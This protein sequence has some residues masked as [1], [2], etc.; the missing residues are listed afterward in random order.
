MNQARR[1]IPVDVAALTGSLKAALPLIDNPERR[2]D[3]ERYL[4]STQLLMER[5]VHNLF[6]GIVQQVNEAGGPPLRLDYNAGGLS[7][8]IEPIPETPPEPEPPAQPYNVDVEGDFE[9][10]TIRLPS[11][12]KDLIGQA[13]QLRGLSQNS[14]YLRE[15]AR[16]IAGQVPVPPTPPPAPGS[17]NRRGRRTLRGFVGD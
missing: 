5:G 9:K 16:A 3:I 14:W 4:D 13:A 8:V 17:E 12:L 7:I 11:E 1:S 6:A 10:V 15:L 2:A